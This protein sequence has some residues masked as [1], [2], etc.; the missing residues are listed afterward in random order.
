M[1]ATQAAD[2]V[3]KATEAVARRAILET[4]ATLA[5]LGGKPETAAI[6]VMCEV[7]SSG[8]TGT[9]AKP[10]AKLGTMSA[11]WFATIETASV[12]LGTSAKPAKSVTLVIPA[13]L[14]I[15]ATTASTMRQVGIS[16]TAAV[17]EM[18]VGRHNPTGAGV[19][20]PE[21][22]G[23][24]EARRRWLPRQVL[25]HLLPLGRLQALTET[26]GKFL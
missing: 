21:S 13:T 9:A 22:R 2:G 8:T 4:P 16:G 15:F 6:S 18:L 23:R 24:G 1:V 25:Q 3:M 17:D 19:M 26:T 12:I 11:T 14:V 5:S 10:P 20:I 7:G